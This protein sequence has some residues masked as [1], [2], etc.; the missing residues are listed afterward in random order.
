MSMG[1]DVGWEDD[2]DDPALLAP[3]TD[4]AGAGD[5]ELVADM[6]EAMELQG[7]FYACDLE[8]VAR[9][10]RLRRTGELAT[11]DGRGGPGVDSRALADAVLAEVAEDFVAELA[12]ARGCSE[13]EAHT[14]LREALLLTGPLS[15]TWCRL[16][17]GLLSVRHAKAVVDLLGDAPATVAAEVQRRVLRACQLFCVGPA[18][19]LHWR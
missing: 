9:L 10:A 5:Y 17:A 14:V 19:D 4:P 18:V 8:A 11:A 3:W 7:R 2:P 13:A 1:P 16:N 6:R 12:L 15:P